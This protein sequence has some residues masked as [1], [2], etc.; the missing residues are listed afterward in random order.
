MILMCSPADPP[1]R[2]AAS[3]PTRRG[4]VEALRAALH[5]ETSIAE[6]LAQRSRSLIDVVG[7][8]ARRALREAGD[9]AEAEKG[10][11]LLSRR[12]RAAL[13][14][15][16]AAPA[17]DLRAL[18]ERTLAPFETAAG[19]RIHVAGRPV[20]LQ[21]D[22]ARLVA[23]VLFDFAGRS[24]RFGAL[25]DPAGRVT[26]AWA[27]AADGGLNL[28][29]REHG[30]PPADRLRRAAGAGLLQLIE[31]RFGAPLR[32]RATPSGLSADLVLPARA[33]RRPD[34][35]PRPPIPADDP[36]ARASLAAALAALLRS[37]GVEELRGAP[38]IPAANAALAQ[39]GLD[40]ALIEAVGGGGVQARI[41][42]VPEGQATLALAGATVRLPASVD[43]LA[44]AV[45]QA[46][47]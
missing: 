32:V 2:S 20:A 37:L 46:L 12:L 23:L 47:G 16:E 19:P 30:G 15:G 1:E 14:A 21:A 28:R 42:A 38:D 45:L 13:A 26:L 5:A 34:G 33:L 4:E 36:A 9:V 10:L 27:P 39:A 11:D 6:A 3:P 24:E 43:A 18:A 40:V 25:S 22:A 31:E 41:V 35:A 29:W 8:L 17:G 7:A 44:A